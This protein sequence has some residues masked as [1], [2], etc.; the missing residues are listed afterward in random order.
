MKNWKGRPL[1]RW[2][3]EIPGEK[4]LQLGERKR[5][6]IDYHWCWFF[7]LLPARFQKMWPFTLVLISDGKAEEYLVLQRE[8]H[9][10]L[11]R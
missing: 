10:C 2:R 9:T 6:T 7:S 8:E 4:M 1:R 5:M 3:E 11:S